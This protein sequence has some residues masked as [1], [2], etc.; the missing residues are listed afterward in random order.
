MN[1]ED[2]G[3][4][5]LEAPYGRGVGVDHHDVPTDRNLRHLLCPVPHSCVFIPV[6]HDLKLMA[7]HV[8]RMASGIVIVNYDFD[9]LFM[10]A[11]GS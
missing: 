6:I 9:A 10:S 4:V 8:P 1:K 2:S 11:G 5:S 7:M 3:I